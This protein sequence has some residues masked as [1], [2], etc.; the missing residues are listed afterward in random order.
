MKKIVVGF[1]SRWPFLTFLVSVLLLFVLSVTLSNSWAAGLNGKDDD[2]FIAGIDETFPTSLRFEYDL[3][4]FPAK[5]IG[6]QGQITDYDFDGLGR[7]R[8]VDGPDDHD[9]STYAYDGNNNLIHMVNDTPGGEREVQYVYDALDRLVEVV[10]PENLGRLTYG[11][12]LAG[13]KTSMTYPDGTHVSY[14]YDGAGRLL[15]V[16]R[17]TDVTTYAYFPDG[18]LKTISYPNQIRATFTYDEFA[19]L[20]SLAYTEGQSE[21]VVSFAYQYDQN[22]N[23]K[24]IEIR[25]PDPSSPASG[26]VRLQVYDYAYDAAQRLIE[27]IYPD[28]RVVTY[29]YDQVGN[30]M[31]MTSDAD[32][33]GPA[34]PEITRYEYSTHNRLA[35]ITDEAG[36]ER[37]RFFYD[38]RGNVIRAVRPGGETLYQY[39]FR[40]L[41]VRAEKDGEVIEFEYDGLGQRTA[42]TV[43]GKRTRLINDPTISSSQVLLEI[44]DSGVT[45]AHYI[46]GLGRV[47]ADLNQAASPHYYLADAIG[48]TFGLVDDTGTVAGTYTYD[49][50]GTAQADGA[51]SETN[52]FRFAGERQDPITGLIYLRARYYDPQ[53]GRFLSRDPLGFIDGPNTYAYARNNPVNF[54]DPDGDAIV[55]TIAGATTIAA[56]VFNA[57]LSGYEAAKNDGTASEI[58]YQ[59]LRGFTQGATGTLA[60]IVIGLKNPF[61][62]AAVG[63]GV[64]EFVGQTFDVFAGQ[65]FNLGSALFNVGIRTVFGGGFGILGKRLFPTVG[66]LPD[67][68]RPRALDR[69]GPNSVRTFLQGGIGLVGSVAENGLK[70]LLRGGVLLNRSAEFVADLSEITGVTVDPATGQIVLVGNDHAGGTIPELRIDD[71]VTAIRAV[72]GSIE[73]P[74]VTIDPQPGSEADASIPQLV[75]FFGGVEDTDLGWVLFEADRVMKTLA[76]ERD[77]VSGEPVTSAVPGYQSVLRRWVEA[78]SPRGASRFWFV[79]GEV[80]LVRS[81]DGQSFLF[82]RVKVDLLTEDTLFGNG[83]TD[84]E[85]LAFANWFTDNYDRLAE[86]IFTVYDYPSE[87][88]GNEIPSQEKIFARLAQV[89][90]A[91]AVVQFFHDNDIPIDFSWIENHHLSERNTPLETRTVENSLSYQ[92]GNIITTITVRGGVTLDVPNTYLADEAGDVSQLGRTVLTSRPSPLDQAWDVGGESAVAVSLAPQAIGGLITRHDVDLSY[93]HPAALDFEVSRF[94]SSASPGSEALGSGWQMTRYALEFSRPAIFSSSRSQLTQFNGLRQGEA[95]VVDRQTGKA[96]TF[97]SGLIIEREGN[98]IRFTPLPEN[99]VP[100]FELVRDSG[101]GGGSTLRQDPIDLSYTFTKA[102]NISFR[103]DWQGNLLSMA[104]SRGRQISYT[105]VDARLVSIADDLDRTITLEYA[106]G[107]RLERAIGLSGD[108]VDYEYDKVGNL[109]AATR[110]R[111]GSIKAFEY[112]YDANHVL[113]DAVDDAILAPAIISDVLGRVVEAQDRRGNILNTTYSL[114]NDTAVTTDAISGATVTRVSDEMGRV[115][116]LTDWL[117]RMTEISYAGS[118]RLPATITLP[119]PLRPRI[120]FQYDQLGNLATLSDPVRGGDTNADGID[121]KPIRFEYDNAD[122]LV[123]ILNARG[124]KTSIAYNTHHQPIAVTRGAGTLEAMTRFAYDPVTGLLN[125]LTDPSGV[126]TEFEHDATGNLISQIVAP[127]T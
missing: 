73:P 53:T 14:A 62:A 55:V 35:R 12:D 25:T 117:G 45:Q 27:A 29:V 21:L 33:T 119:D 46:Y 59:A 60:T 87:Q 78:R 47:S 100:E 81:Q 58:A 43:N 93:S 71:F 5:V 9:R 75:H 127:G 79:P 23:R 11:Y 52:A 72:Y 94:Y 68:F 115:L 89:V 1:R 20:E 28:G 126:I 95:R 99:G 49:V 65:D 84:P 91:V 86:E 24:R 8:A 37:E 96:V 92:E 38:S 125:R 101:M 64:S 32:G 104:D 112:H 7:L 69:L 31:S 63:A 19:R 67:S 102:D 76:A 3:L 57:I 97:T 83:A 50:F 13:R 77:N 110:T 30:R 56:G 105:Y 40:N 17:G 122:D 4:G 18:L 113:T 51:I 109:Q 74:G 90:R 2:R 118:S 120:G 121:D 48:S 44:D 10:L 22:G 54:V 103:F 108:V 61:A 26:A 80:S 39:D 70:S 116:M 41:L 42:M 98:Q 124:I 107:G 88:V 85:A 36:N 106:P 111:D 114:N 34:L 82:E 66:R 16:M 123:G 15:N 6:G